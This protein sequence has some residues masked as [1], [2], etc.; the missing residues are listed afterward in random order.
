MKINHIVNCGIFPLDVMFSLGETDDE[1]REILRN[2]GIKVK[3]SNLLFKD[4][5]RGLNHRFKDGSQIIRMR[6]VPYH[7]EDFGVLLHEIF[8]ASHFIINRVGIK[9]TDSSEEIY[10]YL[11]EYF[12]EKIVNEIA[13]ER[14]K[15]EWNG[16]IY[17]G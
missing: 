15:Q 8:H 5:W 7:V 9:L 2:K 16:N 6:K 3:K 4:K 13:N 14:D 11:I 12:Y 17:E 10:A 1:L